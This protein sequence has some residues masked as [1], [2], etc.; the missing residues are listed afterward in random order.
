MSK[1]NHPWIQDYASFEAVLC[2]I[3]DVDQW[4][5]A[6]TL[7]AFQT[8]GFDDAS[9][10]EKDEQ[11][12][13]HIGTGVMLMSDGDVVAIQFGDGRLPAALSDLF[14][15]LNALGWRE[16]EVYH[17]S[18][19]LGSLLSD[20]GRAIPGHMEFDV[21]AAKI[22]TDPAGYPETGALTERA[23][24]LL[25]GV[26]T[27]AEEFNTLVLHELETMAPE[28]DSSNESVSVRGAS[29]P[30]QETRPLTLDDEL[31]DEEFVAIPAENWA[32]PQ[33][34]EPK[35]RPYG[36]QVFLDDD[37]APVVPVLAAQQVGG[38]P[39]E[40]EVQQTAF[41]EVAG[42]RAQFEAP[43]PTE[44]GKPAE[45]AETA[46]DKGSHSDEPERLRSVEA[47]AFNGQPP[48]GCGAAA[49]GIQESPA[50][51]NQGVSASVNRTQPPHADPKQGQYGAAEPIQIGRSTMVFDLPSSMVSLDD[52]EQLANHIG[53][54]EVVHIW[55]GLT[56]QAHRW[57]LIG[58]I[59]LAAPWFA[60][61]LASELVGEY[62]RD[63]RPAL[64]LSL[65]NLARQHNAQVRDLLEQVLQEENA[66]A[67]DGPIPQFVF[68]NGTRREH[69]TSAVLE[70]FAGLLLSQ[71]GEAFLDV[72]LSPQDD[73]LGHVKIRPFTVRSMLQDAEK[74]LYV[75][76]LD[77]TDGVFVE[78]VVNLL[79]AVAI[80]CA[81]STRALIQA[82][83]VKQE[84][85]RLIENQRAIERDEAI[86]VVRETMA[87]LMEHLKKAGLPIP[88]QL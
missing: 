63:T 88:V 35:N 20:M 60:E 13:L 18:E 10:S 70:F 68:V 24:N 66:A 71:D 14:L 77:S 79:R 73:G 3:N 22:I 5:Q 7:R 67:S 38:I 85:D 1:Q 50:Q 31:G 16:A 86:K 11:T 46:K 51:Q 36:Q 40:P 21:R 58:E 8:Y 45:P 33:N 69:F 83:S 15:V 19:T 30:A 75:V 2:C 65:I 80:R 62:R 29:G 78:N 32:K 56:N 28:Y 27:S 53:A 82:Q 61:V 57:D 37:G 42:F 49:A 4:D 25:Q 54:G 17:P 84:A 47:E 26:K 74:K 23:S 44:A 81:S 41:A 55:P 6:A 12:F 59:D 87:G 76:H 72:R 64:A 52:V 48:A 34:S 9:T 43:E 39:S